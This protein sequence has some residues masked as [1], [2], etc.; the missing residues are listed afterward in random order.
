M[1]IY[2]PSMKMKKSISI[3]IGTLLILLIP[4]I[5]GMFRED[6]NWS[7]ADYLIAAVLLL[8]TGFLLELVNRKIKKI[9]SRLFISVFIV[10][11]LIIIWAELAVG[12]F[13]SPFSG[14]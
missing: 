12:I 4:F 1:A 10:L 2:N 14:S 11:L 6:I 5:G 13:G 3:L 8:S 9:N 7:L